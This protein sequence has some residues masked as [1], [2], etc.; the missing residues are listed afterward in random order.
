[1]FNVSNLTNY[2]YNL[3]VPAT[4]GQANQRVGQTFGSGG[5]RAGQFA[6]RFSF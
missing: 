6:V 5:P 4:F 3:S 2:N 1:V